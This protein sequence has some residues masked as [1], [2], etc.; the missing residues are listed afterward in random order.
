M[1]K[2]LVLALVGL[3]LVPGAAR[4]P[5]AHA[6]G[7]CMASD[8]KVTIVNF[9]FQPATITVPLGTSVCGRTTDR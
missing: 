3:T 5:L 7:S 6:A 9:A 4:V 2:T 8:T 1:R